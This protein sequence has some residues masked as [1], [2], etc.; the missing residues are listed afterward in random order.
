MCGFWTC[1]DPETCLTILWCLSW[2]ATCKTILKLHSSLQ[3]PYII[4]DP[5]S[6]YQGICSPNST[7]THRQSRHQL[8][9]YST[10]L[11]ESLSNFFML[12]FPL[13]YKRCSSLTGTSDLISCHFSNTLIRQWMI[14]S[15]SFTV[16]IYLHIIFFSLALFKNE[17]FLNC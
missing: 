10:L 17:P 12:S 8:G 15:L 2:T 9:I 16:S 5:Q 3:T 11:L 14:F 1:L 4:C 13:V 7:H 6:F